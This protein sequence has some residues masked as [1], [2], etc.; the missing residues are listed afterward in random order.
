MA[1]QRH[2]AGVCNLRIIMKKTCYFSNRKIWETCANF[3][4][5]IGWDTQD[6]TFCFLIQ[7]WKSLIIIGPHIAKQT[8]T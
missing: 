3:G 1:S 4:I 2:L 6:H 7:F 8:N 5:G